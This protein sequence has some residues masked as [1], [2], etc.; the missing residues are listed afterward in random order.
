[1]GTNAYVFDQNQVN[2]KQP[3]MM[4]SLN[5]S[6]IHDLKEKK[7]YQGYPI[8]NFFDQNELRKKLLSK[9]QDIG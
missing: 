2:T 3:S 9:R 8:D 6:V 4:G 5:Q 7:N 1:M